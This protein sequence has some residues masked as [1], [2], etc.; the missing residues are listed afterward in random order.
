MKADSRRSLALGNAADVFL[1][2]H[3]HSAVAIMT[4]KEELHRHGHNEETE[5]EGRG[6][7]LSSYIIA[8]RTMM[9]LEMGLGHVDKIDAVLQVLISANSISL[10]S[11]TVVRAFLLYICSVHKRKIFFYIFAS[12]CESILRVRRLFR[13][14]FLELRF[15]S[16]S[17]LS[18]L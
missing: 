13:Q 4:K 3:S 12:C 11:R 16:S 5:H 18:P 9:R 8:I 2:I 17:H 7:G 6:T 1:G 10:F 15:S 14:T